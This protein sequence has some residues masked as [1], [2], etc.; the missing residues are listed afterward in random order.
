MTQAVRLLSRPPFTYSDTTTVS[1][2]KADPSVLSPDLVDPFSEPHLTY[3]TNGFDTFPA[4]SSYPSRKYSWLHIFPEGRVHQHPN[5]TMRYFKWGV[6]RLILEPDV[7]PDIIPIWIEG[8]EQIFHEARE[9]PRWVPRVGKDVGI[10]FGDNVGGE[11]DGV[12]T[13]LRRKWRKLVEEDKARLGKSPDLGLLSEELKY[14][15]E[16]TELRIEC[17]RRIRR[18]VL[19]VRRLRGLPDED[20]KEGLVET[21]REEG[22]QR[23]GKMDDGSWTKDM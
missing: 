14:G 11:V 21:W 3:S 1:T 16:A 6:A 7:C 4:P 2:T 20:P 12:F 22:R 18:E 9:W 15:K 17:T 13:E 10:W 8:N 19:K 23:E 5:R